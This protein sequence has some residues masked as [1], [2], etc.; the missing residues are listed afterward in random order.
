M[1]IRQ[2]QLIRYDYDRFK[3]V[4]NIVNHGYEGFIV[5]ESKGVS[6]ANRCPGIIW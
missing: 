5:Q 1:D 3:W 2:I 4:L 6:G